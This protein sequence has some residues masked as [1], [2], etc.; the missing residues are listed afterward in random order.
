MKDDIAYFLN[1]A[2]K[3]RQ[4]CKRLGA[5]YC[6]C[7]TGSKIGL[8]IS[9]LEHLGPINGL[10]H[11]VTDSACG[12]YIWVGNNLSTDPNFFQPFHIEHVATKCP[13][14]LPYLGLPPGY[15]FLIAGDYKDI[16][17]DDNL[18]NI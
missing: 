4:V 7:K 1:Y 2:E 16:W 9:T 11:P 17:F 15:R 3:Q 10:R 6:P 5:K 18:L 14:V 13:D 12:W 8:A